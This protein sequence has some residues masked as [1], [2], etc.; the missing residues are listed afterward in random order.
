[1]AA[2][3]ATLTQRIRDRDPLLGTFVSLGSPAVTNL[4]A[5]A[6]YD[7]LL[8]DLEHGAGSEAVLQSQLFAA[9][10]EGAATMVRTET[11]DRIRIGRVLDLGARAIMLPRV[12]TAGQC[13]EAVAHLRYPPQG[14]RGVASSNRARGWSTR[15]DPFT[16]A[17]REIA[18]VVQ[19]ESEQAVRNVDEIAAVEGVDALFVGPSDLS[20]SLGVPGDLQAPVF[21]DAL[22]RVLD[23]ARAHNLAA[24]ILAPT[25]ER[26][27][28]FV[29][30]GFTLIVLSADV[31]MLAATARDAVAQFRAAG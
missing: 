9:E 24:G 22:T 11:F 8:I 15:T 10:A 7:Y 23:A 19:I 25:P 18:A 5:G 30:Q 4:L 13:A 29:D 3:S 16:D 28:A 20:H 17:N 14:D 26:A 27:R 21:T 6:G 2:T 31:N 1:M 12:D